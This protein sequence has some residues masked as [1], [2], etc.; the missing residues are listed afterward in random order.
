MPVAS[1][2]RKLVFCHR[3]QCEISDQLT[4]GNHDIHKIWHRLA[5]C[6]LRVSK[7]FCRARD[8]TP[9]GART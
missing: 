9:S 6:L 8:M 2:V 7:Q 4:A 1:G 5:N 3:H